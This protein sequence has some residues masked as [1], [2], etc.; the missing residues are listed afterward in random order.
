MGELACGYADG[1]LSHA[2]V[3]LA[4]YWRGRCI[5]E[6]SLPLG[7]MAAV[8]ERTLTFHI[9]FDLLLLSVSYCDGDNEARRMSRTV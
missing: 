8:G 1:S 5:K 6:A 2:E 3:I 4:A 9:Y 7:G